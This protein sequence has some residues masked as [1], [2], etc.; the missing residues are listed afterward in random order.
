MQTTVVPYLGRH[1]SLPLRDQFA[2]LALAVSPVAEALVS[3]Q[4]RHVAV[5]PAPGAL[6]HPRGFLPGRR[7]RGTGTLQ[8]LGLLV[9]AHCRGDGD[10][11]F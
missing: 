10:R 9:V 3:L 5:V 4:R 11:G 8:Q 1:N 7:G 6:G 2:F